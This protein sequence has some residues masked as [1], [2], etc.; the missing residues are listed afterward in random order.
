MIRRMTRA[1]ALVAL[2]A[3]SAAAALRAQ[4]PDPATYPGSF[5][6]LAD[7]DT[8][9]S[10][11]QV[12]ATADE[13]REAKAF[14]S[15]LVTILRRDPAAASP[16]G[17]TVLVARLVEDNEAGRNPA[18]KFHFGLNVEVPWWF[19]SDV[20]QKM[21]YTNTS[22]F[23]IYANR[24]DCIFD[25]APEVWSDTTGE[26]TAGLYLEPRHGRDV[27]GT[28]LYWGTHDGHRC[29]VLTNIRKP[30]WLPANQERY[31]K[32][33][34][35]QARVGA[36]RVRR[37]MNANSPKAQ[38]R[39]QQKE[40][41]RQQADLRAACEA[42]KQASPSAYSQCLEAI[43]KSQ[44]QSDSVY[45]SMAADPRFDTEAASV[46]SE[47]NA[48]IHALEAQLAAMSPA[49]R[50][51]PAVVWLTGDH[52]GLPGTFLVRPADPEAADS[53]T[54][55]VV[56]P[57]PDALDRTLPRT[58]PQIITVEMDGTPYLP[59]GYES[60]LEAGA[61]SEQ[62]VKDIKRFRGLLDGVDW[63]ALRALLRP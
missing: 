2:V 8:R 58:A 9:S 35:A 48:R 63:A 27:T 3:V 25:K 17:Y 10:S 31:L 54:A 38:R 1:V 5:T 30:L 62:E 47:A 49:E 36:D 7:Y 24:L 57:N 52:D 61:L 56:V 19:W 42:L 50:A 29:A 28:E 44:A 21:A 46:D 39:Q 12:S 60:N 14:A 11:F 43:R 51:R 53:L 23:N 22:L 45:R 37:N 13:M 4:H 32:A 15:R 20:Y 55:R 26:Y 34:I 6:L 18:A 33:L 59:A 41:P 40:S 16:V